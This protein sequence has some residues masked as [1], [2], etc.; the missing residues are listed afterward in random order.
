MP[1]RRRWIKL[2]DT[3]KLRFVVVSGRWIDQAANRVVDQSQGIARLKPGVEKIR[4]LDC[5]F[6]CRYEMQ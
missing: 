3:L 2:S 6:V 5:G 1:K 4:A